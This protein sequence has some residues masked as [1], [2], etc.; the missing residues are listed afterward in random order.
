MCMLSEIEK[1]REGERE[2]GRER[3]QTDLYPSKKARALLK[4]GVGI[5]S[6]TACATTLRHPS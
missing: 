3:V 5:P 4:A 6:R 2:G 1:E